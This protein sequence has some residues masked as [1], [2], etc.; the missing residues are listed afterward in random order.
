MHGLINRSLQSF[1]QTTYGDDIWENVALRAGLDPEGFEPMLTYDDAL[2]EAAL[3]AAEAELG[4][5][6]D[7]LLE[8]VGAFLVAPGN[9]LER[10]RRLLRFGG[11][12]FV[13]F[14][15]SLDELPDRMR[16]AVPDLETPH[17]EVAQIDATTFELS[18][19]W[20]LPG[21]GHVLVG[22]LRS[23]ADDYGA[24]AYLEFTGISDGRDRVAGDLLARGFASGRDFKLASWV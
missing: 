20:A 6:R 2:T 4:K 22:L 14:L 24:L 21:S 10:L 18:C 13:D 3:D 7:V 11:A 17:I 9:G 23:L 16:L 15:H 1:I 12:S 8:D 19:T 5:A